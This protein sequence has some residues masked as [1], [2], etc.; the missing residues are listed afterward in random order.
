VRYPEDVSVTATAQLALSGT[1]D[2]S[3]ISGSVTLTRAALNPHADLGRLIA[4][5]AKPS[6]TPESPSDYLRGMRFDVRI[7]SSPV[8]ELETAL[9]RDVQAEVDL[10]LRGTPLRPVLLG[11][12]SVNAGEIQ[13]FGNNYTVNRGNIRFQ[14]AVRI[15]PIFDV[16]LETKA[17]GVIVSISLSGTTQN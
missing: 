3:T 8:F 15:E 2:A 17:R 7:Q 16:N 11:S 5:S 10:R 6:P 9:T 4:E 1:S 14:N 12:V 13:L